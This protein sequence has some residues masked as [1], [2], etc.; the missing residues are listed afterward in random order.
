M[1]DM[2]MRNPFVVKYMVQSSIWWI[3]YADLDG[4][5]VD[6]YFYMGE[7]AKNWTAL[8][9]DEYPDMGIVGEIW[10]NQP[11][12]LSYW[13]KTC[14]LPMVMDFPLHEAIITDLTK[15][16]AHWGGKMRTIYNLLALDFVYDNAGKSQVVFI[17]NHDTDRLYNMLKKDSSKV[18][19]AMT[20]IATV[21]GLPQ[22]Y[23]GTEWLFT[24]D[25]R[26]GAHK[27]RKDFVM[28]KEPT[29]AQQDVFNHI[30]TLLNFRKNN[31]VLHDGKFMHYIPSQGVY[32]YFRYNDTD[33]IMVVIN[34]S[35]KEQQ[36]DWAR[37]NERLDGFSGGVDILTGQE[38]KIGDLVEVT[39]ANS[40]VIKLK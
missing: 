38:V 17:D 11:P 30:K 40:L 39:A 14:N 12:V 6:T 27:N 5:R 16:N 3:E 37:F 4:L 29:V 28:P 20:L 7:K 9:R 24:D 10:G 21:R 31:T 22:I 1:P 23:Y 15:D 8:I 36:I 13:L 26:G 2:N 25:E 19:L 18:K 35:D 34:A 33:C 32:T